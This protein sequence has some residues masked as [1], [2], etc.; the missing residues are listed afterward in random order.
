MQNAEVAPQPE[1]EETRFRIP[2]HEQDAITVAVLVTR[3]GSAELKKEQDAWIRT[4]LASSFGDQEKETHR[5]R[6]EYQFN[7]QAISFLGYVLMLKADS[8]AENIRLLLTAASFSNPSASVGFKDAAFALAEIDERLI[9]SILRCAFTARIVPGREWQGVRSA[10]REQ[11]KTECAAHL[12]ARVNEEID[13]LAS[14]GSE[15]QWPSFPSKRPHLRNG[16]L[17]RNSAPGTE[18]EEEPVELR[19]FED[20]GAAQWLKAAEGL[21]DIGVRPW[22][23]EL[24]DYYR[25]WTIVANGADIDK[26]ERIDGEPD[27]WNE[28]Y[29]K[30]AADCVPGLPLEQAGVLMSGFFDQLPDEPLFENLKVFLGESDE[31]FF[32]HKSIA[33]EMAVSIRTLAANLLR[34]TRGWKHLQNDRTLSSPTKISEVVAKFYFN[35]SSGGFVPSKCYLLPVAIPRIT[36]FFV[37]FEDLALD[38]RCPLIGLLASTSLKLLRLPHI[39][40]S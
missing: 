32:N 8:N 37:T 17:G 1:E 11:Q 12:A 28:V 4:T 24:V 5:Y 39:W 23:R 35:T 16:Y 9:R 40:A 34:G 2:L 18:E 14:N 7:P 19:D 29:F 25:D 33:S 3:F 27:S 20:Y 31:L 10:Q 38:C 13:W 6:P 15:P 26:N 21:L 22:L 30:L 36:P